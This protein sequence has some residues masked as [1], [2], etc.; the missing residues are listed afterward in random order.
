MLQ[1]FLTGLREGLEAALIV[2]ILVAYLHRSGRAD[3]LNAIW[4]GVGVAVTLSLGV[5]AALTFT[6]HSL[7]DHAE[8]IFAGITSVLAVTLVTWMVFWMRRQ[9]SQM[10]RDLHTKLDN[11]AAVGWWAIAFAAF[12]AVGREGLETA[13]FLWPTV[14][15]AG[16]ETSAMLGAFLGI[17]AA[18]VVGYLIYKRAVTLN[19][20]VF[21][22][23][24]G[25]ALIVIASGVL[26][27][28]VGDLQDAGL[29]PGAHSIAFDLSHRISPDG[30]AGTLLK[31]TLSITPSTTWLQL[32]VHLFYLV[33]VLIIFVRPVVQ[34]VLLL[35]S[36]DPRA[37]GSNLTTTDVAADAVSS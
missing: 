1:T 20:A 14:K 18:V 34:A 9:A 12:L 31:G 30:W 16:S 35:A 27:H 23:V 25:I 15:A 24:T 5:G 11:A 36:T 17:V 8:E 3:S 22:R 26:A 4:S 13:L 7:S 28:G 21:F 19:L 6:S 10:Q 2:G 37:D 32:G 29:L 33:V